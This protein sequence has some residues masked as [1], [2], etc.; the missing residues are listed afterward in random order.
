MTSW[1]PRKNR[2]FLWGKEEQGSERSFRR[3]AETEPSGLYDDAGMGAF[4][5]KR[6]EKH[7]QNK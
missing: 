2:G 7:F 4:L 6:K 3:Q 1:G 5:E